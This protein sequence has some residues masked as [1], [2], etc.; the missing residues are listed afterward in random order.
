[1]IRYLTI[2]SLAIIAALAVTACSSGEVIKEVGVPG[3]TVVVEREVIKAVEVP[4][5]VLVEREVVKEVEVPVEVVVEKE[6]VREVEVPGETVVVES[7]GAAGPAGAAGEAGT[8]TQTGDGAMATL[9]RQQRIVVR[10]VGMSLVVSGIQNSMDDVAAV[11][12]GMGGWTVSSERSSGFSGSIAVR[13]PAERLDEAIAQIR[14]IAVNV[15]AEVTTSKDVTA[16]YFDSQS[17][18]RNLRAAETAML[19]LLE[20]AKDSR[21]ALDIRNSLFE[22]QE[23]LEV[24]L[25][26]LKLLEETSAFSLINVNMRVARVD[27][28]VDAGP[29]RTVSIGQTARFKASFHS[30]DDSAAY[31]VEWDFGDR[32]EPIVDFFTAATTQ[33]G[34]RVTASVTHVFDDYRDSPYFVDVRITGASESSPLF[35]Q[36]TIK[37]TVLDTEQMPVD[38]GENQTIAVGR[39]VR[40]RAFFEPPEGIDDFTYTWDFGDGT[41]PVSGN[42][43]ILTEDSSRMV[44]AVTNHVY[45]SAEESPYIVQIK[46]VATGEAGVVE[47]SDKAV[48]TV[49][50]LP[51]LIVSAGENVTVEERAQA[52]LSGTFNR[53]AG[54]TNMRYRWG[55]GDGSAPE[56]GDLGEEGTVIETQHEYIHQKFYVATLTVTGD[57]EVGLV[58]ASSNVDV[59]V[60]EGKGWVVG[61]YDVR[62]NSRD[63]VRLLSVVFKGIVTGS[64]L[65][66]HPQ[67]ALGRPD[68]PRVPAEPP[69]HPPAP[70]PNSPAAAQP[71]RSHAGGLR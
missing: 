38:A 18:L 1:M 36:D 14:D 17:R 30:P 26:R 65:D 44:T 35:G 7:Q 19:N 9:V 42:R 22:V 39:S 24:L 15:E 66:S 2:V 28:R 49:T 25:G 13:V 50:E 62:G 45:G 61:G 54:V 69:V 11:A 5:E 68:C 67:P 59:N 46:M 29:D 8:G 71:E 58:E 16:E 48:V 20:R 63:A 4:V 6:V 60:V 56:E 33:P 37:I 53:P 70:A 21:D 23:A 47:G 32:S 40:F 34:T 55:F 52:R 31:Q 41:S 51:A 43:A 10:T 3:E 57:S 12:Y 64:H 27:L